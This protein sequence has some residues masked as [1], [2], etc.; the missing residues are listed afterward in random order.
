VP[1]YTVK[2]GNRNDVAAARHRCTHAREG[3][4]SSPGKA[5]PCWAPRT[6]PGIYPA[7][8]SFQGASWCCSH[9]EAGH[10]NSTCSVPSK[11]TWT[12]WSRP[13]ERSREQDWAQ[14]RQPSTRPGTFQGWREVG[15]EPDP[16]RAAQGVTCGFSSA[17]L[18][19]G[20]RWVTAALQGCAG[21]AA[22]PCTAWSL[23]IPPRALGGMGRREATGTWVRFSA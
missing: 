13:L 11:R 7:F 19:A 8:G 6:P 1:R 14:H 20:S 15:S 21:R 4:S 17:L 9:T 2:S 5:T 18:R 16:P 22:R 12:G 23:P 3:I 10:N